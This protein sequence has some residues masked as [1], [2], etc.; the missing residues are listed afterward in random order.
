MDSVRINDHVIID[1]IELHVEL[2]FS[3]NYILLSLGLMINI[4][5]DTCTESP[6]VGSIGIDRCSWRECTDHN[7]LVLVCNNGKRHL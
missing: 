7:I 3:I 5:I 1:M 4:A 2:L 6:T